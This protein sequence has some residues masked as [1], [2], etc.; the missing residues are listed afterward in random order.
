MT[1]TATL[2]ADAD[3]IKIVIFLIFFLGPIVLQLFKSEDAAAKKVKPPKQPAPRP[4]PEPQPA[5]QPQPMVQ[6]WPGDMQQRANTLE[7]EIEQFL[8]K[9]TGSQPGGA[10]VPQNEPEIVRAEVVQRAPKKQAKRP[11]IKKAPQRENVPDTLRGP[12]ATR[13]LGQQSSHL[14]EMIGGSD[15]RLESHLHDVFDHGLGMF[16][17]DD[18]AH[19]NRISEGTDDQSWEGGAASRQRLDNEIRRRGDSI[20]DAIRNPANMRQAVLWAEIL[21]R[22]D[23][24]KWDL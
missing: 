10:S 9:A 3:W 12:N 2:F 19:T 23:E 6:G 20:R 24:S 8:R 16:D 18:L 15:E 14:G 11:K 13:S 7:E 22:P 4:R 1:S 21:Q 5:P 17:A